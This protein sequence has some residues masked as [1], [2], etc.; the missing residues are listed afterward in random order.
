MNKGV[1]NLAIIS[2]LLFV[3]LATFVRADLPYACIKR[4]PILWGTSM[5]YTG[6]LPTKEK[7]RGNTALAFAFYGCQKAKK[8]ESGFANC[9]TIF[10][11]HGGPGETSQ[12]GNIFGIGPLNGISSAPY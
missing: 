7:D 8:S 6:Y 10:W 2:L 3:A 9:P 1:T 5:L 12:W 11:F 4:E